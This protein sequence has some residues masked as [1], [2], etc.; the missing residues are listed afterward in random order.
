MIKYT[1][2]TLLLRVPIDISEAKIIV[3]F[4]QPNVRLKKEIPAENISLQQGNTIIKVP[5]SQEETGR[6]ASGSSC[7]VQVNWIYE[8]GARDATMEKRISI[9][10]N[11]LDEVITYD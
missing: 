11:L 3:S 7:M 1:T 4:R 5:L 6:L 9:S 8:N 10:D 2:P